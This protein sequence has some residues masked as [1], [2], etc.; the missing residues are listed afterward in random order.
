MVSLYW[1]VRLVESLRGYLQLLACLG[2][3]RNVQTGLLPID[4]FD[5][6]GGTQDHVNN[7]NLHFCVYILPVSLKLM[8]ALHS[9]PDEQITTEIALARDPDRC[10]VIDASWNIDCLLNL[11]WFLASS[12]TGRAELFDLC[13]F[14][15]TSLTS[16][17]HNHHSLSHHFD[18]APIARVA[19]YGL[20]ASFGSRSLARRTNLLGLE[21]NRLQLN[22]SVT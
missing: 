1:S 18:S 6:F 13:S 7:G 21:L 17:L 10:V 3:R 9:D 2:A 22:K 14:A 12:L 16:S 15:P 4:R 20:S 19:F 8:A 11:R 5:F